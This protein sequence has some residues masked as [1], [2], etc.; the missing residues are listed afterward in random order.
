MRLKSAVLLKI[1][2][3]IM[4]T[5]MNNDGGRLASGK[6]RGKHPGKYYKR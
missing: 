5:M 1:L 3:G 2:C 6:S 4:K